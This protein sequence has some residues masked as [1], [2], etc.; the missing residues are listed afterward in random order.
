MDGAIMFLFF[1]C[2]SLR[3]WS[4]FCVIQLAM[5]PFLIRLSYFVSPLPNFSAHITLVLA[6]LRLCSSHWF[7]TT[8][9]SH[10]LLS[11]AQVANC[12]TILLEVDG[13]Q[14]G[15]GIV[16]SGGVCV[17][18]ISAASSSWPTQFALFHPLF[19]FSPPPR[20][21]T[22]LLSLLPVSSLS[23]PLLLTPSLVCCSHSLLFLAAFALT[24][25]SCLLTWC[26][27]LEA[28]SENG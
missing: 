4:L 14:C 17:V 11:L 24:R 27:D 8:L 6:I 12:S 18:W 22:S 26:S 20:I 9:C 16:G 1:V 25:Y 13:V 3:L 7:K 19:I 21:L 23:N 15:W 10:L 2:S 28:D 5:H